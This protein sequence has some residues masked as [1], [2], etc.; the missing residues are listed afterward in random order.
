VVVVADDKDLFWIAEVTDV[1]DKKVAL[2]YYHYMINRNDEKIYKLY[3]STGSCG[4][5]I[6]SHFS[7]EDRIFTKNGRIKLASKK[8]R[9]N[10]AQTDQVN[11]HLQ[12]KCI[13]VIFC[14]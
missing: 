9:K 8:Y 12:I 5:D 10:I 7:T 4:P 2:C 1:D 6:I 11:L 14:I 13:Y 3:N